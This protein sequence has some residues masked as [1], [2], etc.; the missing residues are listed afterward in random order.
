MELEE[1]KPIAEQLK[2]LVEPG[3]DRVQIA[4]SISRQKPEIGDV[5]LLCIP[6]YVAGVDQLDREIGALMTQGILG[7]RL[8]KLGRITYGT[9]NKLLVHRES[10]IGVDV[11]S[12]TEE[13][14]WV[15]LVIRTGPKESNVAIAMAAIRKGWRLLAYGSGFNTPNG[16]L[17]CHSEREVFEAVGLP[18]RPPWERG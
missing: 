3:C 1:A 4:G 6:K 15:A 13:C 10:G 2:R 17:R 18:Y 12:T 11:F 5:E 9:K 16:L 8:N 7:H 14:W